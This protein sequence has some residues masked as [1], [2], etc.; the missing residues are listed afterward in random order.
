M[1]LADVSANIGPSDEFKMTHVPKAGEKAIPK[2][3]NDVCHVKPESMLKTTA[4]A[5]VYKAK[6]TWSEEFKTYECKG[7][8]RF[9]DKVVNQGFSN[10]R[11]E[12][13]RA[14]KLADFLNKR[15]RGAPRSFNDDA[16]QYTN[17]DVM[18]T[19]M[20]SHKQV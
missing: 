20:V 3:V 9:F 2:K 1:R 11:V 16:N 14:K 12:T 6:V 19:S 7:K 5:K 4:P 17:T 8:D 15:Q 18:Q 13:E 10:E